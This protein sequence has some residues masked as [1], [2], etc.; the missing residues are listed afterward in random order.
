MISV[1]QSEFGCSAGD[2][3]CYCEKPEFGYGVRDCSNE[4]CANEEEANQV[5]AYGNE[6]CE[7]KRRPAPYIK[8]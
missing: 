6:Y 3:F 8:L 1:A 4:A 5:I 7:S 2:V